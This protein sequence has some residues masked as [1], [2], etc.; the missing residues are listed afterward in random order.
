MINRLRTIR[1]SAIAAAAMTLLPVGVIA[2]TTAEEPLQAATNQKLPPL[3]VI[4][5]LR[6]FL[7]INPP[8]AVGGSRSRGGQSIC[9][10]S[11]LPSTDRASDGVLVDIVVSEPV[12]LATGELNEVRIEKQNKVLWKDRG[13]SVRAIE[14]HIPWPIQPLKPG[15]EVT[16]KIR[17]RG[18][19]GGDFATFLL[20]ANKKEVLEANDHL[21]KQLG[22]DPVRWNQRLEQLGP[23]EASVAA[24]LWSSPKAPG[25]WPRDINCGNR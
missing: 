22:N 20:K 1:N 10:L 18:A 21:I 23:N 25:G 6:A 12:I 24:A 11:P 14:G 19:S 8:V 4:Q 9:L 16:L 2:Q 17:H 13:D 7:G 3:S 15:E 5:K